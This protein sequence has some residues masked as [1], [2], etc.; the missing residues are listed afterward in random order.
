[1]LWNVLHGDEHGECSTMR[2]QLLDENALRRG[3]WRTVHEVPFR[4]SALLVCMGL[5]H[6]A[7]P[8]ILSKRMNL[9]FFNRIMIV[10]Y[11]MRHIL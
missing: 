7:P 6:V 2:H 3:S 5:V 11:L 4:P 1:M 8:F 10:S 9:E